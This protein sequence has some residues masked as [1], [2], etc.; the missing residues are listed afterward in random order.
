MTTELTPYQKLEILRAEYRKSAD[1]WDK[2]N[3]WIKIHN[4]PKSCGGDKIIYNILDNINNNI[5]ND[6]YEYIDIIFNYYTR[7]MEGY[8]PQPTV[9]ELALMECE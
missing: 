8:A 9:V 4:G 5:T 6:K 3:N 1:N 2:I 7:C